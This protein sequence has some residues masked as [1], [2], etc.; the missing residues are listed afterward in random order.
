MSITTGQLE[1]SGDPVAYLQLFCRAVGEFENDSKTYRNTQKVALEFAKGV[2]EMLKQLSTMFTQEE[3]FAI[4]YGH[5]IRRFTNLRGKLSADQIDVVD[6]IR[7]I[8]R[9][10]L[11]HVGINGIRLIQ[12]KIFAAFHNDLIN[13]ENS[14][15]TFDILAP[16]GK[17]RV[18]V[19][20][21]LRKLFSDLLEIF[22]GFERY[23]N[24][25]TNDSFE[26]TAKTIELVIPRIQSFTEAMATGNKD[27]Q[28][29]YA[30]L[31]DLLSLLMKCVANRRMLYPLLLIPFSDVRKVDIIP[32]T[33]AAF[34]ECQRTAK[35]YW[36]AIECYKEM[37]QGELEPLNREL[38][39][40]QFS[41]GYKEVV[42]KMKSRLTE[43]ERL[44]EGMHRDVVPVLDRLGQLV[45][46]SHFQNAL[47][48]FGGVASLQDQ[49]KVIIDQVDAFDHF[50]KTINNR[51]KKFSDDFE[52]LVSACSSVA[53][54]AM[55][56]AESKK[57]KEDPEGLE[58]IKK[59][60]K[61]TG[62]LKV[63]TISHIWRC[64]QL[65]QF[66]STSVSCFVRAEWGMIHKSHEAFQKTVA[67]RS[68]RLHS[69][70][71]KNLHVF[72]V[73]GMTH[74]LEFRRL[75][76]T[77]IKGH[78]DF[79]SNNIGMVC[80]LFSSLFCTMNYLLTLSFSKGVNRQSRVKTYLK[81]FAENYGKLRKWVD[82]TGK[83]SREIR[84]PQNA[85]AHLDA[86]SK[87]LKVLDKFNNVPTD[88][89]HASF[90]YLN[91]PV[92]NRSQLTPAD[93]EFF[94]EVLSIVYWFNNRDFNLDSSELNDEVMELNSKGSHLLAFQVVTSLIPRYQRYYNV[95]ISWERRIETEFNP[96][97]I[98]EDLAR[99]RDIRPWVWR[100]VRQL[101]DLQRDIENFD[102]EE[103]GRNIVCDSKEDEEVLKQILDRI[104]LEQTQFNRLIELFFY[105][106]SLPL[107]EWVKENP[108]PI[109]EVSAA[110]AR[111][112]IE[113]EEEEENDRPEPVSRAV[114]ETPAV[115]A[116]IQQRPRSQLEIDALQKA[117][118]EM[119]LKDSSGME[120]CRDLI[121]EHY[122]HRINRAI[123][124]ISPESCYSDVKEM[125]ST[126]ALALEQ[127]LQLALKRFPET[128][129]E[130]HDG[131]LLSSVHDLHILNRALSSHRP[132][133]RSLLSKEE[134]AR[135]VALRSVSDRV[136]RYTSRSFGVIADLLKE[137]EALS[138]LRTG[139]MRHP[140]SGNVREECEKK[141]GANSKFWL[142][143]IDQEIIG[144]IKQD[145]YFPSLLTIKAIYSL[146]EIPRAPEL[147]D[148]KHKDEDDWKVES[149][150]VVAVT[151]KDQGET[152]KALSELAEVIERLHP[153]VLFNRTVISVSASEP[154]HAVKTRAGIL[155]DA[156]E[157]GRGYLQLFEELLFKRNLLRNSYVDANG[158]L[159][160]AILCL[161]QFAILP[162]V[163]H[164]ISSQTAPDCHVLLEEMENKRVAFHS[165]D[166]SRFL[167]LL[168]EH[169]PALNISAGQLAL[170]ES[171]KG[172][173]GTTYRYPTREH[174]A[175]GAALERMKALDDM[176]GQELLTAQQN[177][178]FRQIF[179]KDF[180][181]QSAKLIDQQLL[182]EIQRI[183][184]MTRAAL[185][186]S[187]QLAVY[188]LQVYQRE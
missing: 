120:E 138:K 156:V 153:L 122:L 169:I 154:E 8:S 76:E 181:E 114:P 119:R 24:F 44:A 57:E 98:A 147:D 9:G 125:V 187:K 90:L 70:S 144:R 163:Y 68:K 151:L 129:K 47:D 136:G 140:V 19:R 69:A 95:L 108:E 143:K 185:I 77:V 137:F 71:I 79:E 177:K 97:E 78:E 65:M 161:E 103:V 56:L 30:E 50:M 38:H 135:V 49:V 118:R 13:R 33:R 45:R 18:P 86:F 4:I 176:R 175:E 83:L 173:I 16:S 171:L 157:N 124:S 105:L 168:S 172:M 88:I 1:V 61:V 23:M 53:E 179:E 160:N 67:V 155:F 87:S 52:S 132:E 113:V 123:R 85:I 12:I 111:I 36:C 27:G 14:K 188:F 101:L 2:P 22:A 149:G 107:I 3:K 148:R 109:V 66:M 89:V 141:Y 39:N 40:H 7:G 170:A 21:T 100:F 134:Q 73:Q 92:G 84:I 43:T 62:E 29:S 115:Q 184:E 59:F 165:H 10:V 150:D 82:A 35:A 5:F 46:Q 6:R 142:E 162:L 96:K 180:D 94:Q 99:N 80:C 41:S 17:T 37:V 20:Q 75:G 72:V 25:P 127:A 121:A 133:Q 74:L 51:W 42:S 112:K 174:S 159:R 102:V 139:I 58:I 117:L 64:N 126:E 178:A 104:K 146:L 166:V 167:N 131:K 63:R 186:L 106:P 48:S 91:L 26:L 55:S 54:Q 182:I 130:K 32:F 152:R 28:G 81:N 93:M 15:S 158:L 34:E 128:E 60:K 11:C 116:P 164:G 31:D 145:V 110:P 183:H